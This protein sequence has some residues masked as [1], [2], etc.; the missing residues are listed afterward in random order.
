MLSGS[1]TA[2]IASGGN[3]GASFVTLDVISVM[4]P[5]FYTF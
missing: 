4:Q 3:A 5:T 2:V 1:E